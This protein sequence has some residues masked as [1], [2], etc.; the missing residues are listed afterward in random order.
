MKHKIGILAGDGVGPEI[1]ECA[2]KV[3]DKVSDIS[4]VEF[5]YIDGEIG[6]AAYDKFNHPFPNETK[7]IIDEC[8]AILLGA[9]GGYK[10]DNVQPELR[11]EKGLLELRKY[12]K[13]FSNIRPVRVIKGLDRLS[14]LK[15]DII[16]DGVDLCIVRELTGGIYFGNRH[17]GEEDGV[18]Y[19]YDQE[20]Y[21][22]NE[23]RRIAIV[24]FETAMK[25]N[26]KLMS[27]D[28]KNV[29][30]SSKLW[31]QV[32]EEV[33]SDYPEVSLEHM[34]V[35]NAAMQLIRNPSQFDT[36]LTNNIFGDIL[37]DEASVLTGSIG[38]LPS[39]SLGNEKGL[40][41]PIHGSAPDI[42]GMDIA[43][44]VGMVL[45]I[46]MMLKHSFNMTDE[47]FIIEKAAENLL[48]DGYG[49]KD[50]SGMSNYTKT[51]E[52][53]DLLIKKMNSN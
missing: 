50:L 28:K 13:V 10:W 53:I 42:A 2:K 46:A 11:P 48:M 40:Y 1:M 23:I 12:M 47:S 9:V 30:D 6:G 44:P 29:L 22:E 52:W 26:K 32:V 49:T 39:A 16:K 45:S 18:R 21:N 20:Y 41:E 43:N 37:S 35:D 38:L 19:A 3:L 17:T 15:T 5:D 14:P 31:R 7:E 4:S 27:V 33:K 25:R 36:I 24:A 34:Y 8:D 51:S